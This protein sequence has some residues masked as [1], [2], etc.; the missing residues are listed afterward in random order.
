MKRLWVRVS[1]TIGALVLGIV[2]VAALGSM[3]SRSVGEMRQMNLGRFP[4]IP[5]G[6]M[7]DISLRY[8]APTRMVG[9]LAV[10]G[11][12][13]VGAGIWMGRGISRPIADLADAATR[14]GA[15]DLEAR[16]RSRARSQELREL[17]SAFN[18]MAAQLQHAEELRNTLMADISHELR[19]PL[20]VLEGNLRAALDNVVELDEG[21]LANLYGQTRHLIRL[22]NDLRDLALAEAGHLALTLSDVDANKLVEEV[23]WNY[24]LVAEEK[25]VVL[26]SDLASDLPSIVADE[27]RVR[28]VLSNL[29]SNALRHTPAGGTILVESTCDQGEITL[30]VRDTGEGIVPDHLPFLFDRFYRTDKSRTR[31]TGG[32]GLGLAVVKALVSSLGGTVAVASEGINRGATFTVTF[33]VA[34]P[35]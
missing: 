30:R 31:E 18:K 33:P 21:E 6:E 4:V 1:T 20:T 16:V 9:F 22:V 2:V 7:H 32:S 10:I 5:F 25:G 29:I 19:G 28:Q 17:A 24:T 11:L 15:G 14:L 13:G 12:I 34:K 23:L 27:G 26:S 8:R 35:Q 3:L